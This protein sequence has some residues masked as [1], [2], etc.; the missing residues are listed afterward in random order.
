M[1]TKLTRTY[2]IPEGKTIA[3][4]A[5][6]VETLFRS[7]DKTEVQLTRDLDGKWFVS[8]ET[9]SAIKK[10]A[11]T[12]MKILVTIFQKNSNCAEVHFFQDINEIVRAGKA[13]FKTPFFLGITGL[14]GIQDR[15]QIPYDVNRVISNYL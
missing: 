5:K 7:Y 9:K 12:D 14:V 11:G 2:Q 3:G 8:C 13:I 4:M 6:A 10:A 15:H 1:A